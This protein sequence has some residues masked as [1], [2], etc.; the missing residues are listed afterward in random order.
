MRKGTKQLIISEILKRKWKFATVLLFILVGHISSIFLPLVYKYAIDSGIVSRNIRIVVIAGTIII[1]IAF[2]NAIVL[3]FIKKYYFKV[4]YDYAQCIASNFIHKIIN[5]KKKNYD[6]FTNIGDFYSRM[7]D[8]SNVHEAIDLF[9]FSFILN[10]VSLIGFVSIAIYIYPFFGVYL[11]ILVPIIYFKILYFT[12]KNSIYENINFNKLRKLKEYVTELFLGFEFI[13]SHSIEK[14]IL[15]NYNEL[16]TQQ[17]KSHFN[18]QN[19]LSLSDMFE[20][21]IKDVSEV[22][23]VIVGGTLVVLNT[24]SIGEWFALYSVAANAIAPMIQLGSD[25][26]R[27][28]TMRNSIQRMD[29]II[30]LDIDQDQQQNHSDKFTSLNIIDLSFNYAEYNTLKN[31]SL[32]INRGEK[33][34]II[35]ESGSGKSTFLKILLGL[36]EPT[37]GKILYNNVDVSGDN[38]FIIRDNAAYLSQNHFFFSDSIKNNINIATEN[39]DD[40][41]I[42]SALKIASIND[43]SLCSNGIL[44]YQIINQSGNLSEGQKQRIS[45]ARELVRE[46]ELFLL[47]EPTSSIDVV[48]EKSIIETLF[49]SDLFKSITFIISTHRLSFVDKF[50]KIVYMEDGQIIGIGSHADLMNTHASYPQFYNNFLSDNA[51][52][53]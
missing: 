18:Y 12:D 7:E 52:K 37:N 26:E 40:K 33:I 2:Y 20:S 53:E 24:I 39:V 6:K 22:I 27:V 43:D 42:F 4:F 47:D 41:K 9:V 1:L 17:N 5:M 48:S 30:T 21:I 15:K 8:I 23:V 46:K 3:F 11:L 36:Y 28:K 38:L 44:N 51:I 35:G 45:I 31:I 10:F 49:S 14:K 32:S 29:Q 34:G 50:D 16:I 19:N 25:I 13:K